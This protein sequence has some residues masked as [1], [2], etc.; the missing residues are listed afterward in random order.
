M[1]QTKE[2]NFDQLQKRYE[3]MT[4]CATASCVLS[5]DLVGGQPAKNKELEAFVKYQMKLT[6]KAAEE[7][8]ARIWTHELEGIGVRKISNPD[9]DNTDELEEAE[10]KSVNVIRRDNHGPWLGDW[11]IKACIKN[12]ATRIHLFQ[13]YARYG[14]K[15]DMAEMG[16][17]TAYGSSLHEPNSN[18][19]TANRIYLRKGKQPAPTH[20]DIFSGSVPGPKGRVSIQTLAECCDAGAEFSFQFRFFDGKTTLDDIEKLFAAAM[21]IGLGSSRSFE[22]GKFQITKLSVDSQKKPEKLEAKPARKASSA[23]AAQ[24]IAKAG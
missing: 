11:M 9:P 3:A 17:A 23:P 21:N 7:A 19:Y 20:F 6:G 16:R 18:V 4:V 14:V 5:T 15:G 8:V 12:A 2:F 22:R 1:R 13:D 24:S 10:D